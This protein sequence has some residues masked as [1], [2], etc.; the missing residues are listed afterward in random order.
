M[1]RKLLFF[2]F[3]MCKGSIDYFETYLSSLQS[4]NCL[5]LGI[6]IF[7]FEGT[8]GCADQ[9]LLFLKATSGINPPFDVP[10][11]PEWYKV[12]SVVY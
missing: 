11:K 10:C 12:K 3:S 1:Y 4:K 8:G 6:I 7:D 2:N 5:E 9:V